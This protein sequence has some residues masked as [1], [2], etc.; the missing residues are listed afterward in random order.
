LPIRIARIAAANANAKRR[1]GQGERSKRSERSGARTRAENARLSEAA[2]ARVLEDP[3]AVVAQGELAVEDAQV[4]V[5]V[6]RV[7]GQMTA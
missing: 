2:L 6:T 4:A 7:E 1:R 3:G 5:E